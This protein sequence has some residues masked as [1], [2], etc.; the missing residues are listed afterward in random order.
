MQWRAKSVLWRNLGPV[1][2]TLKYLLK[3]IGNGEAINDSDA[4]GVAE[5]SELAE[6][7]ADLRA[8]IEP[9][10]FAVE[11]WTMESQSRPAP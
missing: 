5:M 10:Q 9:N 6:G 2:L 8:D 11:P 1:A 3:F 4:V 7:V